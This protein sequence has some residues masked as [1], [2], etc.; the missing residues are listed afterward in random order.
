MKRSFFSILLLL[1]CISSVKAED[2]AGGLGKKLIP[3]YLKAQYA[4]SIG[5]GSLGAGWSYG[6]KYQWES[7]FIVGVVPKGAYDKMM[8]VI[9]IKQSYIPWDINVRNSDFSISPLTC[10][11]F[12]SSV[13]DNHFWRTEPDKYNPPYYGFPTKVRLNLHVGQRVTYHLKREIL[14]IRSISPYYEF[15][16]SDFNIVNA[17]NNSY[18]KPKDILSVALGV[19]VQF[20]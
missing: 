18:L 17:V 2:G 11:I 19:K 6:R 3:H 7:D 1:F 16:I 15:S 12:I 10:G 13:L 5:A 4:G 20:K 14:K 8:A 9:T